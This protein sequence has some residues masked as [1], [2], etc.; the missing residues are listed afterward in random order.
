MASRNV[1][2]L[3]T[4]C[5]Q[6]LS[7]LKLYLS[8]ES[9]NTWRLLLRLEIA[10]WLGT[11]TVKAMNNEMEIL[12]CREP[13]SNWK[14]KFVLPRSQSAQMFLWKIQR[15]DEKKCPN[16]RT[17]NV[18]FRENFL[19]TTVLTSPVNLCFGFT[20]NLTM[21]KI[22]F[23]VCETMTSRSVSTLQMSNEG[24]EEI[25]LDRKFIFVVVQSEIEL[26]SIQVNRTG[27]KFSAFF[28]LVL[29]SFCAYNVYQTSCVLSCDA[30]KLF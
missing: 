21:R 1:L 29:E 12:H 2:S 6:L 22:G 7:E 13:T 27:K 3:R 23:C 26:F 4:F 18:N 15:T 16:S 19:Q 28:A 10:L 25:S 20:F 11:E 5:R 17:Q 9:K 24:T 30:L 8:G 14:C